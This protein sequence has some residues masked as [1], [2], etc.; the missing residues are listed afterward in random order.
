MHELIA[1]CLN[2]L[3]YN[4]RTARLFGNYFQDLLKL[5]ISTLFVGLHLKYG[6]EG[7]PDF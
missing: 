1:I 7:N 4:F 2:K 6:D 3:G 5:N